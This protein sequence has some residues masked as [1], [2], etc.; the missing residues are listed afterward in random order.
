M[1]RRHS[2]AIERSYFD[3][4][5]RRHEVAPDDVERIAGFLRTESSQSP[6]DV[7]VARRNGAARLTLSSLPC[8][9]WRLHDGERALTGGS[10]HES[11]IELPAD[12]APGSYMLECED[13]GRSTH[14]LLVAP[15]RAFQPPC[16]A[17]GE[18]RW[19]LAV[20]LY[21]IRS[22]RNWGHGDFTDLRQLLQ[23]ASAAGAAG[24]G[25]NPLHALPPGQASP[26]SPSSRL[27]L[28]PL[29]IDL[30]AVPEFRA[31]E[32]SGLRGVILD[33]RMLE[34]IDYPRVAAVKAKALRETYRAFR[35][36]SDPARRE[37]FERFRAERGES[38][39]RYAAF[40]TLREQYGSPWWLWPHE[41]HRPSMEQLAT[42][43][44]LSDD[45]EFHAFVQWLADDQ[46]QA[47]RDLAQDLSLPVGLYLD[48]AVGVALDGADAWSAQG[49]LAPNLVIGAP[50]DL[51]NPAGQNWGIASF[52]PQVLIESDFAL[53]R[54]TLRAV[55]R[56]AGAIRIDHAL[57][58]NRVFLIPKDS[59]AT[60]GTYVSF[61]F[62][63]M[64]A[65][66]A[67]ESVAARCLVI[68]EDLGTVPEGVSETLRDWGVWSYRVALFE[69]RDD[70]SFR[71]PQEYP[72]EAL[73]TFTTHDLPTFTGWLAARDLQMKRDIGMDPGEAADDRPRARDALREAVQ[74]HGIHVQHDVSIVDV[75]RF[76]ARTPCGLLAVPLE[77]VLGVVDQI[78]VPGT[79]TEYR[80]WLRRMPVDLEQLH[81]HGNIQSLAA[82]LAD[83]GRA[84]NSIRL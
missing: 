37:A 13:A 51:W 63:A 39:V 7:F 23:L 25:V 4:F 58:L 31:V 32:I 29:Y 72:R 41:W 26:Y 10:A 6:G 22:Q 54:E 24:V 34:F 46:L 61:P 65:V 57:G 45:M 80:N 62:H 5:G 78:N 66:V 38:L 1:G 17:E 36:Q 60:H 59:D 50:P 28:N 40:E 15:D 11:V 47:C 30:E 14:P 77:D 73:V 9:H 67:Q 42:L 3:A 27:F 19:V 16:V 48:L 82:A 52:H 49:A 69:R 2:W 21:A 33:L 79:V 43:S 71:E 35:E 76:L 70:G 68:G 53:L 20:Q 83:E 55:M 84:A 8:S 56:Y 75:S 44:Q 12:L 74:R 18:R 81:A 64:L